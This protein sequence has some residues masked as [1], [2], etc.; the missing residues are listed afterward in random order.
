M[1]SIQTKFIVLILSC[2]LF[3]SLVIGGA[4]ILNATHVADKDSVQYMNLQCSERASELNGML[5][6]IEQSVKTLS[7]YTLEQLDSV[8]RIKTDRV[9]LLEYTH[10]LEAVAVNAANNTALA[11]CV[12]FNPDFTPPASGLFWSKT[13]LDGSLEEMT[14]LKRSPK[15]I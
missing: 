4:G 2:V 6:R 3:S 12:R 14:P 13:D 11:I 1:K 7:V 15:V 9:Y 8:E 10:R 5:S